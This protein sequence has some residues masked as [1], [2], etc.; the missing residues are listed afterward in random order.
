MVQT[1]HFDKRQNKSDFCKSAE[2]PATT[3]GHLQLHA[4]IT[5]NSSQH[6]AGNSE[7]FPVWRH[8][9]CNVARWW[10]LVVNSFIVRCHVTMNSKEMDS[11]WINASFNAGQWRLCTYT[12]QNRR[13]NKNSAGR[14]LLLSLSIF[15]AVAR[16][17]MFF[18]L[19]L[20]LLLWLSLTWYGYGLELSKLPL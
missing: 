4:L 5:C 11:P 19:P 1:D 20:L 13:R 6:F 10:H 18:L 12:P 17:C 2:I 3:S 14:K 8:S 15:A 7:H 16:S 9:F